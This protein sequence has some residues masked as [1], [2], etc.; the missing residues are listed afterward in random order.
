[1]GRLADLLGTG[2]SVRKRTRGSRDRLAH[3]EGGSAEGAATLVHP[4]RPQRVRG[5]YTVRQGDTLSGI[6][7]RYGTTW[8]QIHA[9]NKDII[10]SDPDVIVP[11]QRLDI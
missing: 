1:M 5:D 8:Q 10:G 3:D 9:A 11:G 4:P 2:R 7:A 6:A